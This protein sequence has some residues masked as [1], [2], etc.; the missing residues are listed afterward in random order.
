MFLL[1]KDF[2]NAR[3]MLIFYFIKFWLNKKFLVKLYE[4]Y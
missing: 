3:D 1:F 2:G 4:V